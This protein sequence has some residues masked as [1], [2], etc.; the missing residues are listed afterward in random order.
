MIGS[1]IDLWPGLRGSMLTA[2]HAVVPRIL[3]N[4]PLKIS[5]RSVPG[6]KGWVAVLECL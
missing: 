4:I 5:P 1:D 3:A 6:Q 2:V